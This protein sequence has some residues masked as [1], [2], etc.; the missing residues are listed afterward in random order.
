MFAGLPHIGLEFA[1]NGCSKTATEKR[2][3][4]LAILGGVL[5]GLAVILVGGSYVLLKPAAISAELAQTI[6]D[7]TG[8][9]IS[10]SGP[11]EFSLWPEASVTLQKVNLESAKSVAGAAPLSAENWSSSPPIALFSGA[12]EPKSVEATG[13]TKP[14]IDG[15]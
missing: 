13:E 7:S 1:A 8:Y 6:K 3:R 5:A 10:V 9:T 11:P 4:T 14:L 12:F 2:L 15:G